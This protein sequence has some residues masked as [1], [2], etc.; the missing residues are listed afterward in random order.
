[1]L[2]TY[3]RTHRWDRV[4]RD[5]DSS[6]Q[7]RHV[8]S[9]TTT[10]FSTAL[11]D[12]GLY[13][14]PM[15]RNCQIWTRDGDLILNGPAATRAEIRTAAERVFDGGAFLY[16]FEFP[17]MRVGLHEVFWQRPLAACWSPES[18]QTKLLERRVAW[19]LRCVRVCDMPIAVRRSSCIPGC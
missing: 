18:G 4:P 14:K 19:I 1:M 9:V 5:E 2:N 11:S 6:V 16:R 7:S 15:A 13:H 8:D 10:L 17:A 12:L 3:A